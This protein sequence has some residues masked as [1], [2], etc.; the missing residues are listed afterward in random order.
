MRKTVQIG[1]DP[2]FIE[3]DIFG[4]IVP[5]NDDYSF[6]FGQAEPGY[7]AGNSGYADKESRS[8]RREWEWAT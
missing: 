1:W 4:I 2:E 6:D 5:L 8:P 7:D 3:G